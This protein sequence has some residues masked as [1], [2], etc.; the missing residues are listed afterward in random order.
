[1]RESG[2]NLPAHRG[3]PL[4][5]T[6]SGSAHRL[7]GPSKGIAGIAAHDRDDCE[8]QTDRQV[9][10]KAEGDPKEREHQQL[11]QSHDLRS[12]PPRLP[13]PQ[14]T[15]SAATGACRLSKPEPFEQ[16]CHRQGDPCAS[17]RRR[18]FGERRSGAS[19]HRRPQ[20]RS[21]CAGPRDG[22]GAHPLEWSRQPAGDPGGL[23]GRGM[24][25]RRGGRRMSQ[26]SR[27]TCLLP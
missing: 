15:T 18:R 17:I 16:V 8:Y 22:G 20:C 23:N 10:S 26:A 7:E 24:L 19:G 3:G 13:S 2:R 11:R 4:N 14:R 6:S 25:T 5:S 1:M 12:R 27:M 21:A 9:L